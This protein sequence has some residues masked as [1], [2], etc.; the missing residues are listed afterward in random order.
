[1]QK[2]VNIIGLTEEVCSSAEQV[3][4]LLM[5]G[6]SH[7]QI[8]STHYNQ[9]SSRSH[10]MYIIYR[11]KLTIESKLR[12]RSD[13]PVNIAYCNLIDLAGSETE[14]V[15]G[16]NMSI[17]RRQEVKYINRVIFNQSLLTLGTVIMRLSDQTYAS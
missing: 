16:P 13:V 9:R 14:D 7:K 11:F 15:H 5:I 10:T 4:S 8:A 3:F 6:D 2:G 1:M 12:G 17:Y